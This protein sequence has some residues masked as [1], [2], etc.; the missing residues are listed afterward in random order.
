LFALW[1]ALSWRLESGKRVS[2]QRLPLDARF[3][4]RKPTKALSRLSDNDKNKPVPGLP[5][6]TMR[7]I[8]RE[9]RRMCVHIIA[10]GVPERFAAIL[11]RLDEASNEGEPR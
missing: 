9:L 11:H 8:G 6:S 7:A 5:P 1:I 4:V 10:E 3:K 2:R